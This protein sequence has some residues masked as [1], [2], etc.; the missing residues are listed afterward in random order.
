M[1]NRLCKKYLVLLEKT[2]V[3]QLQRKNDKQVQKAILGS[4][5]TE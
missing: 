5:T 1:K 2:K 3:T 4:L